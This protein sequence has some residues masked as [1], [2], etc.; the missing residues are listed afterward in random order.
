MYDLLEAIAQA[1]VS[2]T[3]IKEDIAPT[4]TT[5]LLVIE[6][7]DNI[8]KFR[9]SYEYMKGS[10]IILETFAPPGG[11]ALFLVALAAQLINR[12]YIISY[13]NINSTENVFLTDAYKRVHRLLGYAGIL[14]IKTSL[15]HAQLMGMNI[16]KTFKLFLTDVDPNN[17]LDI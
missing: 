8:S 1:R 3:Y 10:N 15:P 11:Y 13:K 4:S 5:E 16:L 6:L 7:M 17:L 9:D 12:A 14:L 2:T